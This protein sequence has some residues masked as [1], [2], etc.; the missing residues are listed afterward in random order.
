MLVFYQKRAVEFNDTLIKKL[1]KSN[2]LRACSVFRRTR[3]ALSD[4]VQDA[5]KARAEGY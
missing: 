5:S 2:Y 4:F 1:I 3:I